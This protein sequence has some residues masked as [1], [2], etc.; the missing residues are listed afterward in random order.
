[1]IE[2]HIGLLLGS[3]PFFKTHWQALTPE[4]QKRCLQLSRD[5]E[6]VCEE[7]QDA[8]VMEHRWV[9]EKTRRYLSC[10]P[11]KDFDHSRLPR[12]WIEFVGDERGKARLYELA[13][14]KLS[15]FLRT[16]N[17]R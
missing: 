14:D 15:G 7:S 6:A 12:D 13:L 3:D 8:A 2:D 11:Q 5:V 16:S 1:M 4:E 9:S 17:A 10:V